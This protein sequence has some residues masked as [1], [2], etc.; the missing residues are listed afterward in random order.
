MLLVS[1]EATIVSEKFGQVRLNAPLPEIEIDDDKEFILRSNSIGQ[2]DG[3]SVLLKDREAFTSVNM[4][5]H[6]PFPGYVFKLFVVVLRRVHKSRAVFV[7]L[8]G[9]VGSLMWIASRILKKPVC[10]QVIGD[11]SAMYQK[12]TVKNPL[13]I[14]ALFI[15][16]KIQK[17]A[18]RS[19]KIV[20]YVSQSFLQSIYPPGKTTEV[21]AFSDV[22]IEKI[23]KVREFQ[24]RDYFRVAT[25]SMLDQPYKGVR[26]LIVAVSMLRLK[27]LPIHL[28]IVGKGRMYKDLHMLA[29]ELI[30]DHFSFITNL[31][32]SKDVINYLN[33]NS[34][35]FVL[36]SHTEGLPRAM[37]E[38]MSVGIPCIGT[39]AGGMKE[40]LHPGVTF[41]PKSSS[42]IA[43]KIYELYSNTELYNQESRRSLELSRTFLV[44][45]FRVINAQFQSALQV[46]K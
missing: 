1:S 17:R 10:V 21:F 30:P 28:T 38:A 18:C 26:E 31:N 23:G 8:P 5:N 27:G 25:V 35:L 45:N 24:H 2:S 40:L 33:E 39:G 11:P 9:V 6:K 7:T 20:R 19:A 32:S 12:G 43:E 42:A 4:G 44:Q 29:S 37:V 14:I 46:L 13:R 3:V 22:K 41:A 34:D 36:A 16:P 15:I